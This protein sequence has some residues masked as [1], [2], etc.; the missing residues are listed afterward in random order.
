MKDGFW[1]TQWESGQ[2][3]KSMQSLKE[4]PYT[5]GCTK[6]LE[7]LLTDGSSATEVVQAVRFSRICISC[8]SSREVGKKQSIQVQSLPNQNKEEQCITTVLQQY[9]SVNKQCFPLTINQHKPNFSETN[10]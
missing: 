2:S 4:Q 8:I 6:R 1:T 10:R 7:M 9:F 5:G 3:E